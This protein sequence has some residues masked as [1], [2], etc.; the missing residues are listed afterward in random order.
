MSTS[1]QWLS[2]HEKESLEAEVPPGLAALGGSL[3]WADACSHADLNEDC[4]HIT[5]IMSLRSQYS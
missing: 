2:V 4:I 3:R 5:N 1:S